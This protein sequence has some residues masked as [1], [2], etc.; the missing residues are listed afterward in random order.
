MNRFTKREST[1]KASSLPQTLKFVSICWKRVTVPSNTVKGAKD[2][3]VFHG[4]L[5]IQSY[6]VSAWNVFRKLFW[7]SL[8]PQQ[9]T[10]VA[11]VKSIRIELFSK[12]KRIGFHVEA[13][14]HGF[15]YVEFT[16]I[17]AIDVVWVIQIFFTF[18]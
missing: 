9:L 2:S 13:L 17:G 6:H 11:K 4:S 14:I 8:T 7:P 3:N 5:V 15:V 12:Q 16:F 1:L 18:E 10:V